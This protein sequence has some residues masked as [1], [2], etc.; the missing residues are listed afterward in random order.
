MKTGPKP[1]PVEERFWEKVDKSGECWLWIGF[2]DRD[3]YGKMGIGSKADNSAR[4]EYSNRLSWQIHFGEIPK[5]MCVCHKCDNPSCVKPDH[6]FL[7]TRKDNTQDMIR[8]GR[9]KLKQH[10]NNPL[11]HR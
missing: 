8:K 4:K 1:R 7:G 3:G 2:R 11:S 6:L 10:A 9:S 5:G